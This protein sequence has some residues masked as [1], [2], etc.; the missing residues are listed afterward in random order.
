MND[1]TEKIMYKNR[2]YIEGD[3]RIED[4]RNNGKEYD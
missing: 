2:E 4:Y 3:K 1:I